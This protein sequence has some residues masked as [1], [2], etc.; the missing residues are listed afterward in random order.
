MEMEKLLSEVVVKTYESEIE[1]LKK[2]KE[3][4]KESSE[5]LI[6]QLKN[7]ISELR[8]ALLVST[9]NKEGKSQDI[10]LSMPTFYNLFQEI[11][12]HEDGDSV[13]MEKDIYG[14]DVTIH[15][16]G[17]STNCYDGATS[18][19]YIVEEGLVNCIDECCEDEIHL[20]D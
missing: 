10:E 3:S 14:H 4:E 7:E 17:F 13:D 16:H 6:K 11:M 15:W 9:R 12:S 20:E 18:Y 2:E 1:Q 19:N 8:Q 5:Q